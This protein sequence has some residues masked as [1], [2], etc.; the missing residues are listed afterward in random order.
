VVNDTFSS[1]AEARIVTTDGPFEQTGGDFAILE[2]PGAN[3]AYFSL[4]DAGIEV[5]GQAVIAAGY[6]MDI[7]GD[8]VRF[9]DLMEG[10]ATEA[11]DLVITNGTV[12]TEQQIFR[13]ITVL[14][15]SASISRGNSGGPLVDMCGRVVG[16]NTFVSEQSFRF[17]NIAQSM[18]GL[19]EFLESSGVELSYEATACSPVV[20]PVA[21][22]EPA[23]EPDTETADE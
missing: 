9:Q 15:H 20:L 5:K 18:A 6:P 23:P 4:L 12:N 2:V 11:P 1:P 14:I 16:M 10:R 17:L 7:V 21:P 8:D 22:A 19:R 3:A 13:D